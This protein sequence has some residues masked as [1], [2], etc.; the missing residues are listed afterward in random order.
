MNKLQ[1]NSTQRKQFLFIILGLL[2]YNL[3]LLGVIASYSI[4]LSAKPRIMF[5]IMVAC[6]K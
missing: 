4:L 6:K 5:G 3:Q 1:D 2:F